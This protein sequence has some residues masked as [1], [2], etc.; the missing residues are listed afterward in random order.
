MMA[1]I[2]EPTEAGNPWDRGCTP[3]SPREGP[4][5]LEVTRRQTHGRASCLTSHFCSLLLGPHESTPRGM[6]IV[7][8]LS[9]VTT[10][11][12]LG[13]RTGRGK[14]A[15]RPVRASGIHT[16]E[17]CSRTRT[18]RPAACPPVAASSAL[19]PR[20]PLCWEMKIKRHVIKITFV[21]EIE[22]IITIII[23]MKLPSWKEKCN[24]SYIMRT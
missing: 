16:W 13:P 20:S 11:G 9:R 10:E 8:G 24:F 12:G 14:E 17:V 3:T 6:G 1:S 2:W 18:A 15:Q 7:P 21:I 4:T 19:P 23:F 5:L 22:R